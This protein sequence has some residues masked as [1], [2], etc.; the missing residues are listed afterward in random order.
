VAGIAALPRQLIR[1]GRA[2]ILVALAFLLLTFT[3]VAQG[4][5][6]WHDDLVDHLAGRW[7][8][9]GT[10]LGKQAHHQ[11]QAE[12]VLNHQ[13]LR[14]HEKTEDKAGQWVPFADLVLTKV[15]KL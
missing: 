10:V 14:I 2:T 15:E 1:T 9:E 8:M 6:S 5:T 3:S 13:F 4:P 7:K 12:W 11:V